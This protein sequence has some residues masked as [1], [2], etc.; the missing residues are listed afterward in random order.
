MSTRLCSL[1]EYGKLYDYLYFYSTIQFSVQIIHIL[2]H[3]P[4]YMFSYNV[5]R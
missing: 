4:F 1:L 5:N 2:V 3:K